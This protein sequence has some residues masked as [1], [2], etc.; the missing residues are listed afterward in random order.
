MF[1]FGYLVFLD[2]LSNGPF[3]LH[4]LPV[5]LLVLLPLL[6]IMVRKVPCASTIDLGR[7]AWRRKIFNQRL[8]ST[9]FLFIHFQRLGN[10]GQI[11]R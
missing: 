9:V 6:R 2:F 7:F 5:V 10:S 3:C 1:K 4:V 8:T 11:S